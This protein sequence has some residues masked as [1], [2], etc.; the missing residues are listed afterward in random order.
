MS[1][2]PQPRS[3]QE[4]LV[5]VFRTW[6]ARLGDPK[7]TLFEFN[8][9]LRKGDLV[10]TRY[11]EGMDP[12]VQP[13]SYWQQKARVVLNPDFPWA[14]HLGLAIVMEGDTRASGPGVSGLFC[15]HEPADCMPVSDAVYVHGDVTGVENFRQFRAGIFKS[16]E[17]N[18]LRLAGD[19]R[20]DRRPYSR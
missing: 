9:A 19:Q 1:K 20:A 6:L 2:P 15:V 17:I 16:K 10:A 7:V 11:E 5:E 12:V 8:R 4:P 13:V 14:A 18:D 3:A